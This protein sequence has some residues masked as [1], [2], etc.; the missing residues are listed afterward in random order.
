M[1]WICIIFSF[2]LVI[3]YSVCCLCVGKP[4]FPLGTKHNGYHRKKG[5][6]LGL[7]LC[8]DWEIPW[9]SAFIFGFFGNLFESSTTQQIQI[10]QVENLK[11]ILG[12]SCTKLKLVAGSREFYRAWKGTSF[13]SFPST[14][15]SA[16][17]QML[18]VQDLYKYL[19]VHTH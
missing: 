13:G 6:S 2:I 16:C 10:N 14:C 4:C 18:G 7:P 11:E 8:L 5:I 9:P 17:V 3:V 12:S 1:Q 15:V 19:L